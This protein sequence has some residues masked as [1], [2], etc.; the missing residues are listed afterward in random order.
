MKQDAYNTLLLE[1]QK[2]HKYK[3]SQSA[4][5][6]VQSL[7]SNGVLRIPAAY[8]PALLKEVKEKIENLLQDDQITENT[9]DRLGNTI[10]KKVVNPLLYANKDIMDIAL[11][12]L[13]EQISTGYLDCIPALTSANFRRSYI[14]PGAP[15]GN[16]N[17]HMDRNS[18]KFLKFFIYLNDVGPAGGPF[19]YILG[20]HKQD[21]NPKWK[22]EEYNWPK[23]FIEEEYGRERVYVATGSVGDLIVADTTGFH[24]GD[25]P[26]RRE[27]IM[28][29]FNYMIHKE[30][31]E[32]QHLKIKRHLYDSI[33]K[34][35]KP[36]LDFLEV[37]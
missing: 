24:C 4:T 1:R 20:S 29:T 23:H 7:I 35:K 14:N 31:E 21:T 10:W 37:I 22:N 13:I 17:Y 5:L 9:V 25:P 33:P 6:H 36:L 26:R 2:E 16:Q 19:K 32:F 18:R 12:D 11:G 30:T 34:N 8:D 28:L 15:Y 27:R 3:K